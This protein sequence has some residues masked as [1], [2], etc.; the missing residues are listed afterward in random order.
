MTRA[1]RADLITASVGADRVAW[2]RSNGFPLSK[3]VQRLI[4][5]EM[6]RIPEPLPIQSAE[7]IAAVRSDPDAT[8]PSDKRPD[9]APAKPHG[10]TWIGGRYTARPSTLDDAIRL[11]AEM[12]ERGG[13]ARLAAPY[14]LLVAEV[15][16]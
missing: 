14:V 10:W 12:R 4:D 7:T 5:A 15:T 1:T 2:V 9:S 11:C 13:D 3:A 16:P 8:D 6:G